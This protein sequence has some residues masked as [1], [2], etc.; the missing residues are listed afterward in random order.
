MNVNNG[1]G[2]EDIVTVKAQGTIF[3]TIASIE[4]EEDI[5]DLETNEKSNVTVT[6]YCVSGEDVACMWLSNE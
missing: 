6:S 1:A 4:K 3:K 2:G 5:T